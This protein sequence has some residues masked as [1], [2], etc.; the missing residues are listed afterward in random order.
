MEPEDSG[1]QADS[2]RQ[3]IQYTFDKL[4]PAYIL[5]CGIEVYDSFS[6]PSKEDPAEVPYHDDP[7]LVL[8]DS[9]GVEDKET[10]ILRDLGKQTVLTFHGHSDKDSWVQGSRRTRRVQDILKEIEDCGVE[11]D[12]IHV[13][14]EAGYR[15]P[16]VNGRSKYT[17]GLHK[18]VGYFYLRSGHL[19]C[20][21]SSQKVQIKGEPERA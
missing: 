20:T 18:T 1:S 21:M 15:L 3:L 7:K 2:Q 4:K 19:V 5:P 13:C 12:A 10:K 6:F 11:I 16:S 17:Y 14:N 8:L 9:F